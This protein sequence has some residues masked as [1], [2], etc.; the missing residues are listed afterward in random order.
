MFRKASIDQIK[1]RLAISGVSGSGKTYSSLSIAS[2]LGKSIAVIDTEHGSSCR[3]ADIFN[4]D[5]CELTDFHPAKYIEALQQ[6][7]RAGYE[8]IILDSLSHAWFAE[9]ALVDRAKNKFTAWAPVRELER[10]LIA[11]IIGCNAHVICTMRSKTEWNTQV[12]TLTGKLKPEKIG[13]TPIQTSGIEYE[14]DLFGEMNQNHTLHFSKSRCPELQD[15]SFLNPGAELADRLLA[16]IKP[17]HNWKSSEDAVAW[18][19]K[20][21]PGLSRE[22]LEAEFA[23]LNP[24]NGK[25]APAWVERIRQ[26]SKF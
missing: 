22:E 23:Q 21:L 26:M 11:A 25:K 12:D 7:Q 3:Y 1:I 19:A 13:T 8:T 18:A 16:W 20:Q 5:V 6:A 4:F 2:H 9:L 10:K 24:T 15:R 17:W 14:F